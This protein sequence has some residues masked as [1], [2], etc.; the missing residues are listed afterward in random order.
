MW[1]NG[2]PTFLHRYVGSIIRFRGPPRLKCTIV[3]LVSPLVHAI[4]GSVHAVRGHPT[5]MARG[6]VAPLGFI[7][8]IGSA[9]NWLGRQ[10]LP[11]LAGFGAT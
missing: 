6:I 4:Y 7:N 9:G 11:E 1:C 2:T 8:D 3:E 5:D 10:K